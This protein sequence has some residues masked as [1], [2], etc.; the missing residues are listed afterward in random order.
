M[1]AKPDGKMEDELR[2][3]RRRRRGGGGGGGIVDQRANTMRYM[4][5]GRL[6]MENLDLN[7]LLSVWEEPWTGICHGIIS[8]AFHTTTF[9]WSPRNCRSER[10]V[11]T[12]E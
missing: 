2:R 7:D 3:R 10:N 11:R 12:N 8:V 1:H 5:G 9:P 4:E 6:F